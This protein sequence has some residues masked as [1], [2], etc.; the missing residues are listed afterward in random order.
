M[1]DVSAVRVGIDKDD[2]PSLLGDCQRGI[3]GNR[4]GPDARP[5]SRDGDNAGRGCIGAGFEPSSQ[6]YVS[7]IGSLVV[8]GWRIRWMILV[9]PISIQS[10]YVRVIMVFARLSESAAWMSPGTLCPVVR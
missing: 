4:G 3:H 1:G 2:T 5:H 9:G 8:H 7:E 10:S 6:N